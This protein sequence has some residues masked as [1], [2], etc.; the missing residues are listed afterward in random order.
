MTSTTQP[1][2]TGPL[3]QVENLSKNFGGLR[4]VNNFNLELQPGDL[5]G[6]IGPNGA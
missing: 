5:A 2:A 1:T 3:L 4:A 6:L